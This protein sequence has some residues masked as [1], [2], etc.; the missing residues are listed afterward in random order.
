MPRS[1][2]C[3]RVPETGSQRNLP[4]DIAEHRRTLFKVVVHI[5]RVQSVRRL[6]RHLVAYGS[7]NKY[8]PVN[9]SNASGS[10]GT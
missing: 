6:P 8:R 3:D 1:G 10:S 2:Y 4:T 5:N 9:R 7:A